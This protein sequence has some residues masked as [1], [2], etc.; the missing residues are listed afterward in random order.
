MI[1]F[2]RL[3]GKLKTM[4][5]L[6]NHEMDKMD[7]VDKTDKTAKM[8]TTTEKCR[9][10]CDEC[11]FKR[12][13]KLDN[14]D[15]KPGGADPTVYIGQAMGPFWLPCH[16]APGYQGKASD[17]SQVIQCAG[18]AVFRSNINRAHL[19]PD[20]LLKL[21][22]DKMRVFASAEE[23]LAHYRGVSLDQARVELYITTPLE[24]MQ[25]ELAKQDVQVYNLT[26]KSI[27]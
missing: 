24:L 15:G 7:T 18:A 2:Q 14:T 21:P 5:V 4:S 17:P 20:K 10:P 8:D 13:N 6:K 9:K 3:S 11:P 23:M 25:A 12:N 19:L 22:I 26:G 16:K 27:K 1:N